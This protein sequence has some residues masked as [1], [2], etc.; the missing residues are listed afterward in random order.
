MA[1]LPVSLIQS[2]CP[3]EYAHKQKIA[4]SDKTA[5]RLLQIRIHFDLSSITIIRYS[6]REP[7]CKNGQVP[8]INQRCAIFVLGMKM[9]RIVVIVEDFD[10]NAE[11]AADLRHA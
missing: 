5:C 1:Q 10:Q 7:T 3:G 6:R 8:H 11:E 4:A 2:D 9:L